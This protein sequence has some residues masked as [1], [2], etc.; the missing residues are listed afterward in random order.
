MPANKPASSRTPA[1]PRAVVALVG[2]TSIQPVGTSGSGAPAGALHLV[3]GWDAICGEGRVRFVFP[4]RT[5]AES[6]CPA[7]VQATLPKPRPAA[8]SRARAS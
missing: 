1:K 6:T 7:C 2:S 5:A 8:R 3:E 4:G